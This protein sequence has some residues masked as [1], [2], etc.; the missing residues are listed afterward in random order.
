MEY[1]SYDFLKLDRPEGTSPQNFPRIRDESPW[2]DV[3]PHYLSS[4]PKEQSVLSNWDMT[5]LDLP[6]IK[7]YTESDFQ[8]EDADYNSRADDGTIQ[9]TFPDSDSSF[10]F[11]NYRHF[12]NDHIKRLHNF[13]YPELDGFHATNEGARG[14]AHTLFLSL[15]VK[16]DKEEDLYSPSGDPLDFAS[17]QVIDENIEN[18]TPCLS[19]LYPNPYLDFLLR[20]YIHS[21]CNY[22]DDMGGNHQDDSAVP[23][24]DLFPLSLSLPAKHLTMEEY[25]DIFKRFVNSNINIHQQDPP[26]CTSKARGMKGDF[27]PLPL[28]RGLD[29]DLG[30]KF[31]SK[32]D[33]L[34]YYSSNGHILQLPS[35]EDVCFYAVEQDDEIVLHGSPRKRTL[36][37]Y[38]GALSILD[39]SSPGS[40][41]SLGKRT[42]H[43]LLLDYPY[44]GR[45]EEVTYSD[46][47]TSM[48]I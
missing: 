9:Y 25:W 5:A 38:D 23:D 28:S 13:H 12:G 47:E 27:G 15:D 35:K 39:W 16:D 45:T 21:T 17:Q 6:C 8:D 14:E 18:I 30:W 4:E 26:W 22:T 37:S 32:S 11:Q 48:E 33:F 46:N 31:L 44:W 29:I 1:S 3:F 2:D 41:V 40:A 34:E 19:S 36:A 24:A 10:L 42:N 43:P 7:Y 20:P